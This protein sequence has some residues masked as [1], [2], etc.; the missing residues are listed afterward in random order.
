MIRLPA[1]YYEARGE[2]KSWIEEERI[3][4]ADIKYDYD[5]QIPLTQEYKTYGLS[6]EGQWIVFITNYLRRA[7]LL[8]LDNKKGR[9][10]MGK[11]IVTMMKCLETAIVCD[12]PMPKAGVPSGVIE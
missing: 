1:E 6:D 3:F 7:Q 4:Y 11:C 12:G 9:Q 8:G 2:L 5:G 10:A